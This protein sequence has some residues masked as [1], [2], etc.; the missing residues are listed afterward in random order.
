MDRR[1]QLGAERRRDGGEPYKHLLRIDAARR[2]HPHPQLREG[3]TWLDP[4]HPR[5]IQQRVL[6]VCSQRRIERALD[7]TTQLSL[8]TNISLAIAVAKECVR[9]DLHLRGS[10]S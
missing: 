1:R 7:L 9:I 3:R 5:L 8:L 10:M 6:N 4:R 2:H